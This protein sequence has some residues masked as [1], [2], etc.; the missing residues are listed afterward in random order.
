MAK[1]VVRRQLEVNSAAELHHLVTTDCE[2]LD[3]GEEGVINIPYARRLDQN[4]AVVRELNIYLRRYNLR[5]GVAN[6]ILR[7]LKYVAHFSGAVGPNSLRDFRGY[8]DK[9]L[10]ISTSSKSQLFSASK[11]F[12]SHFMAAGN[13]PDELLP[14][15]FLQ[16]GKGTKPTFSELAGSDKEQF[17]KSLCDQIVQAKRDYNLDEQ[18]ALTY[19]Y[20][21][22][23]M[24][25]IHSYAL[26]SINQWEEDWSWVDSITKDLTQENIAR[27]SNTVSF[28]ESEFSGQR[29]VTLAFQILFSKYG[30]TIPASTDWPP[31]L[32]DFLKGRRWPPRR[33]GGAFFPTTVQIGDFLT[34]ILSHKDLRPNVDAV[35]FGLYLGNVGPAFE[36]GFHSVF[37][38]KKR[39]GSTPKLL[40][41][42]DPL[43]KAL[44]GLQDKIRLALPNILGGVE[45]LAQHQAEMLIHITPAAGHETSFRTID[46]SS[47][48]NL[49]QRVIRNASKHHEL[50]G[51]LSDKR[52]S[53]QN[54]RP[55]HVVI[56]RLSGAS[57]GEIKRDLD[58]QFLATTSRY[59]DRIETQ[60]VIMGKYQEFQQYLVDES[61]GLTR[62]GSG[63]F[64]SEP[65]E[66]VCG[67][68][69]KCFGC[70]AKRIVLSSPEVAAEWIAWS[71][72]IEEN[73]A[74]LE[75]NNPERWTRYWAVKLAE[76]QA[77]IDQLDQRTFGKASRLAEVV[78][79]PQLD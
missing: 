48:S 10:D 19:A 41:S 65:T 18:A 73:R 7:Y 58:H 26:E 50:L 74:S 55:T 11:N 30:R 12:V 69:D 27:L 32:A 78:T 72:K 13:I 17:R 52:A 35:A 39:G 33:V 16:V 79:L 24:R 68:I 76:Y 36:K 56:K 54:F 62:T 37:F 71:K 3:L 47:A 23:A 70:P 34:A 8:I 15:G 22:E 25:L 43:A 1:R 29:T 61:R 77:L 44:E 2:T 4:E 60:S 57:N 67:D 38:D 14:K 20:C 59:S 53:G 66:S 45:H 63:Y 46:R 42:S 28:R 40:A 75:M 6:Q 21:R 31:G 51:P 9:S 49:V 5:R 64:C